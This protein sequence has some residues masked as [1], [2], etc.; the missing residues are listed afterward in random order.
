MVWNPLAGLNDRGLLDANNCI[1]GK[2]PR[3][4]LSTKSLSGKHEEVLLC[5]KHRE[6]LNYAKNTQD[7]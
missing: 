5:I 2:T 7:E 4:H 1:S 3:E 6:I